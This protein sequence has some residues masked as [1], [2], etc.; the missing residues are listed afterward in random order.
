MPASSGPRAGGAAP[1]LKNSPTIPHINA[2][3]KE[4]APNYLAAQPA[5]TAVAST[6]AAMLPEGRHLVHDDIG[7]RVDPCSTMAALFD[8]SATA[9]SPPVSDVSHCPETIGRVARQRGCLGFPPQ[10]PR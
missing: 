5:A 10:Q 8:A 4:N 6:C 1:R 9:P 7:L 2:F 3:P